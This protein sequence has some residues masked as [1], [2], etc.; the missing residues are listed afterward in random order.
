MS[1]S[2]LVRA[3]VWTEDDSGQAPEQRP[4]VLRESLP[5]TA[6]CFSGGGTRSMVATIG[7]LRG[8]AAMGMLDRVGYVS[9]VSGSAWAVVPCLFAADGAERLGAVTPPRQLTLEHLGHVSPGSLLAPVTATSVAIPQ[10]SSAVMQGEYGTSSLA[11]LWE[12]H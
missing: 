3:R 10:Y 8:L 9:C 2:S 11:S 6:V 12:S 4:G 5:Q 1:R 7:Q